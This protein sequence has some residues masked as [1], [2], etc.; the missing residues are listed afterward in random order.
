MRRTF[1]AYHVRNLSFTSNGRKKFVLVI[2]FLQQHSNF[3]L[4]VRINLQKKRL[5][6]NEILYIGKLFAYEY[7]DIFT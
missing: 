2:I 7:I 3:P 4:Q 6:K 5:C 1:A